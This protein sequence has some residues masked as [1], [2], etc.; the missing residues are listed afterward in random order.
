MKFLRTIWGNLPNSVSLVVV[1]LGIFLFAIFDVGDFI[2]GKVF[3]QFSEWQAKPLFAL[4]A[5]VLIALPLVVSIAAYLLNERDIRKMDTWLRWL[6]ITFSIALA[7]LAVKDGLLFIYDADGAFPDIPFEEG[8][9]ELF[10]LVTTLFAFVAGFLLLFSLQEFSSIQTDFKHEIDSWH[11]ISDLLRFFLANPDKQPDEL[12]EAEVKNDAAAKNCIQNILKL[13]INAE[14]PEDSPPQILKLVYR[15]ILR[16]EVVDANDKE[17]LNALIQ[18]YCRLQVLLR[19]RDARSIKSPS[20][21]VL[22][23]WVVASVTILLASLALLSV[24]QAMTIIDTM[25]A[26]ASDLV[27]VFAVTIVAMPITLMNVT[28]NDLRFPFEG[29]WSVNVNSDYV[30]LV[31]ALE[32]ANEEENQLRLEANVE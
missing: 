29:A 5:G 19:Q 15:D 4:M 22:M 30:N 14:K 24:L 18:Q 1:L 12:E 17:A 9:K 8:L 27:F 11:S 16:L 3:A 7:G 6:W 26:A 21:L 31:K 32:I 28:I 10:G 13:D 20:M 2:D 25:P 23:L